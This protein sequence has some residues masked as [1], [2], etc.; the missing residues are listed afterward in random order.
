METPKKMT[1]KVLG[2]GKVLQPHLG[3]H[4]FLLVTKELG[5]IDFFLK[6]TRTDKTLYMTEIGHTLSFTLLH[7]S[8]EKCEL[9]NVVN[10]T[11]KE[12]IKNL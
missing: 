11:M 8:G 10:E 5:F 7:Q 9:E 12:T 2:F 4:K 3:G 1:V 6:L